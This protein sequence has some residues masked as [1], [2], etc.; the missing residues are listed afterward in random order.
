LVNP[1]FD[2]EYDRDPTQRLRLI[3]ENGFRKTDLICQI[4]VHLW[5]QFFGY[6]IGNQIARTL[7][8]GGYY[9]CGGLVTRNAERLAVSQVLKDAIHSKPPH[10]NDI[11]RN[12]PMYIVKHSDVGLLG[13]RKIAKNLVAG[14]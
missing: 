8:Y 4:A 2:K 13:A 1:D 12:V 5:Q 9:I 3:F 11:I 14:I 6:E 10:I 7:P